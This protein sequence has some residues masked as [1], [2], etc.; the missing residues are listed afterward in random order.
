M[1]HPQG[2]VAIVLHAHLPFVRHPEYE[3]FLEEDWLYEAINETYIPLIIMME[4]LEH[5]QVPYRLTMSL[6]PPLVSMLKDPLLQ[7]RYLRELEKLMELAEKEVHRTR[8]EHHLF[9]QSAQ[10]Y[11]DRFR[12]SHDLFAHRYHRDLVTAFKNFQDNGNL[13]IVTCG[14]THG[15]LPLLKVH[16]PSVRAQI[17]VARDHYQETFGRPPLG[18]WL[19][20]CAYYHGVEY[21]LQDA[22][23]RYFFVD[24][25]GLAYGKPRPVYGVYAPVY[26]PAGVAA[27]A[28]DPESSKQVWS[29]D[30]GYPGDACY[31][32]FYRD[33]GYDREDDYIAP[34][35]QP[36]GLRKNTGI[37]YHRI[38]GKVDLG[39]KEPY[40]HEVARQRTADHAANFM[41]NRERQVEYLASTLKRPPLVVS[42]Y[43]A[44]LYGHWWFEGPQFLNYF[45]RKAAYD[46][47]TFALTHPR[48]Y[49]SRFPEQQVS[50]PAAST[51]GHKGYNEVWLEGSNQWIYRPLINASIH[52]SKLA[53]AQRTPHANPLYERALKQAGRELLLAQSSDWPFIM[54][55]G[56]MVEYAQKRVKVHLGRFHKLTEDIRN[57]TVDA[58]W[59]AA[60]EAKDNIFPNLNYHHWEG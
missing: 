6:T 38:T 33:V 14:A 7:D 37:K 43:D 19:A 1:P 30:E 47:K 4:G 10:M 49:L 50:R 15:F 56:T 40:D 13:E 39:A 42:P 59:L 16:E 24:T 3:Y 41:F 35:V 46:Q 57:H 17:N 29:A 54:K 5:D 31:R 21:F 58:T 9:H 32:D 11:L 51:W 23:I 12:R 60:V 2:Y 27:F 36:N 45:I 26:T 25:H 34:Y 55:T 28:R 52:M 8:N 18:I 48:E 22:G 44:E 20:E 53:N